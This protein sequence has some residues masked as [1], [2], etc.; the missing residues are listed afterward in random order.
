MNSK[1][2][3][4]SKEKY[5][6]FINEAKVSLEDKLTFE[7]RKSLLNHVDI[8]DNEIIECV[9][10]IATASIGMNRRVGLLVATNNRIIMVFKK[11]LLGYDLDAF[12]YNMISN[13]GV[14][15][16]MTLNDVIISTTGDK[17]RSFYCGNPSALVSIL[18][19]LMNRCVNPNYIP[20]DRTETPV[21]KDLEES[22][23]LSEEDIISKL[24][25]LFTLK[26]NGAIS[27]EEYNILKLKII[28]T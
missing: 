18:Q 9:A 15:S 22:N 16:T 26:Q 13:F 6:N 19:E 10:G 24:E 28:N 17:D 2:I 5:L 3:E 14:R 7:T 27:E 11:G 25:R 12:Y 8:R 1:Q 4:L 20:A 21:K 23:S